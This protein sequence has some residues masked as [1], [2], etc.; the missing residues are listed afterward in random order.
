MQPAIHQEKNPDIYRFDVRLFVAMYCGLHFLL[1]IPR[2]SPCIIHLLNSRTVKVFASCRTAVLRLV[3][4]TL[5][6]AQKFEISSLK[7]TLINSLSFV[8]S[9]TYTKWLNKK[10]I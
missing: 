3:I 5:T 2:E 9:I 7:L 1:I 4:F 10:K 6:L 8:Q